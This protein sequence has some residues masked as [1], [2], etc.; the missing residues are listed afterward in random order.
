ME[1]KVDLS[2]A[3]PLEV[4]ALAPI[5]PQKNGDGPVSRIENGVT[6]QPFFGHIVCECHPNV[7][8]KKRSELEHI[9]RAKLGQTEPMFQIVNGKKELTP[10]YIQARVELAEAMDAAQQ[11]ALANKKTS[12]RL[13]DL[14]E[15]RW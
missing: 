15:P 7:S 12:P 6:S 5:V 4:P 10:V 14:G 11:E 9:A 8:G 2:K 3:R 1:V 13:A